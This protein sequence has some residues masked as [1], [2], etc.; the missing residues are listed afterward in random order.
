MLHLFPQAFDIVDEKYRAYF[1]NTFSIFLGIYIFY[2]IEMT[3]KIIKTYKSSKNRR[4]RVTTSMRPRDDDM[5]NAGLARHVFDTEGPR[6][7]SGYPVFSSSTE[8]SDNTYSS[9]SNSDDSSDNNS[10][11]DNIDRGDF[12][13]KRKKSLK[14]RRKS[15]NNNCKDT[16]QN[17]ILV[18]Y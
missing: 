4:K 7:L 11:S 14:K 3:L 8:D 18:P 17:I 5:R 10:S 9:S 13:R 16:N 12:C 6:R 2:C 1:W 15:K